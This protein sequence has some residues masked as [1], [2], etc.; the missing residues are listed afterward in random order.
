MDGKRKSETIAAV[1][2][3]AIAVLMLYCQVG[4]F[5]FLEFDDNLYVTENLAVRRGFETGVLERAWRTNLA[6]NWQPVT[7]LSHALDVELF[8]LDA[9]AHHAVNIAWHTS[10]TILLLLLAL[11]LGLPLGP[12]TVLALLFALHPLRIESVAW[13][14][15]RKDLLST[16]FFLSTVIA[17]LEWTRRKSAWLYAAAL[18]LFALGLMSK[19]ML[20][21]LPFVLLLLD[22]WPLQR[23]ADSRAKAWARLVLEKWPFLLLTVVFCVVAVIAQQQA[24]AVRDLGA[25]PLGVRIE[26]ALVAYVAYLGKSL[27]PVDLSPF[28]VHPQSWPAWQVVGAAAILL[29]LTAAAWR[30]RKQQPWWLVGWLWYLGTLVP[31]IGIVQIGDQWMADR[32]TYIPMIG[33]VAAA[34]WQI[35]R[36][37]K[38]GRVHAMLATVLALMAVAA[39]ALT[40]HRHL[41]VW[42]D[43]AALS[44][45]GTQDGKAHWSMR[46][47]QA[48][49][50]AQAGKMP[51]AIVA[52]EAIWRDHPRDAE[53]AN[54]L[55]FA[56]LSAGQIP[57]SVEILRE[58]VA[59]D[60]AY[61]AA[62]VN[63]GKASLQIG[64]YPQALEQ[65]ELVM[66]ADPQDPAAYAYAAVAI[67]SQNPD[68][69]L[70]LA[71]RATKLT[72]GPNLIAL[73]A[74]GMAH[75]AA[76]RPV[77][78]AASWQAAA[79]AAR[80]HG[81]ERTAAQFESK[82]QKALP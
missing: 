28:Y 51:E 79:Q 74:A 19:V 64:R 70:A 78:A 67:A 16:F 5:S 49:A 1:F 6:G 22:W 54:N 7:F 10:N 17:Y 50:L 3:A 33:P 80:Q 29:T 31:V 72:P 69:A 23:S 21:T 13:V 38:G 46:T 36:F 41:P 59:L 47:N 20:V 81:D 34:V 25:F 42:R 8:G 52:F 48:I 60:P 35:W 30:L 73:D 77:Q 40:S 4:Q 61:H 2:A 44:A 56:L 32:Y 9:G 43:T 39:L 12:S 62:R 71:Q 14:A 45:A 55:G 27:W 15:E 76:G 63:L 82:A 66:A 75:A 26:T 58:A 68:R 11:L 53:S 37:S 57:R 65:F 24:G 18:G